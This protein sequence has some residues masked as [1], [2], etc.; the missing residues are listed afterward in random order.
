MARNF[1]QIF[2]ENNPAQGTEK[3]N[4]SDVN[5]LKVIR[6]SIY[7]DLLSASDSVGFERR[8]SGGLS[9][10]RQESRWSVCGLEAVPSGSSAL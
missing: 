2:T 7:S 10:P 6:L 9:S 1:F 8:S 4:I 3:K 5:W